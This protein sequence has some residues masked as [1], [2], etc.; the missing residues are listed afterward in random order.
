[1]LLMLDV[2][3]MY[4]QRWASSTVQQRLQYTGATYPRTMCMPIGWLARLLRGGRSAAPQIVLLDH[5]TY[6]HLEEELRQQYCQLWCAFVMN[7]TDAARQVSADATAW[8]Y[9]AS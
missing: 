1:M 4:R 8:L 5:G 7:D 9:A 2:Q 3:A 6:I